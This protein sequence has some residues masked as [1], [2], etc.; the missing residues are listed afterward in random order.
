[1]TAKFSIGD[2]VWRAHAD[3]TEKWVTCPDCFG[4]KTLR[5]VLGDG[6]EHT[7]DC[8]GCAAGYNPPRGG[9]QSYDFTPRAT[10]DVITEIRLGPGGVEYTFGGWIFKESDVFPTYEEAMAR[11]AELIIERE[12]EE[13]AAFLRKTNPNRSWAWH[14]HYHRDNIRQAERNLAFHTEK[15]NVARAK[16]KEDKRSPAET[17]TYGTRHP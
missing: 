7:M 12:A 11:A 13:K 17:E 4:T 9:V 8:A 16:A 1:M 5:V 6:T 15:L 3:R 14:V 10:N 2:T